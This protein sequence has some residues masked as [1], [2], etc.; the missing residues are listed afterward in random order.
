MYQHISYA[1]YY[2]FFVE[3]FKLSFGRPQVDVCGTCETYK[4]KIKD[5]YFNETAKR[6]AVAEYLVHKRKTNKFYYELKN[7]TEKVGEPHIIALCFDFMQNI[8]LPVTP[9]GEVFYYNELTTNVFCIHNI[10]KNKATLYTY[11]EG[12]TKK[13]PNEVCS[14]LLDYISNNSEGASEL[15]LYSDNCWGQ[16]KNHALMRMLLALTDTKKFDKILQYFPLR[17]HSFLP[18]D[19]DFS[20]IKRALKKRDRIY[21][22]HE[23]TEIIAN[24]SR[25]QKFEVR[26]VNTIEITN[27][28]AWWPR[29]YKNAVSL[30]TRNLERTQKVHFNIRKFQYFVY[31]SERSGTA[32]AAEFIKGVMEHT[33]IRQCIKYVE[34]PYKEFYNEIV[35]TCPTK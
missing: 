17:G 27:F 18:F 32:K 9:V 34:D 21:N 29:F 20:I 3:K 19:R 23:L 16:N 7:E 33:W 10:K 30:E 22:V 24:A 28:K 8:Q 5:D 4:I 35:S 15:H 12:I 13:S 14:L 2:K 31:D 1:S 11:H 6:V 26:E 25:T